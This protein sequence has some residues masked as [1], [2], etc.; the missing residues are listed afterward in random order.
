[1]VGGG[2]GRVGCESRRLGLMMR[3]RVMVVLVVLVRGKLKER[4][5]GRR[6]H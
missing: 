6:G 3:V 1:M 5:G 4:K 2:D